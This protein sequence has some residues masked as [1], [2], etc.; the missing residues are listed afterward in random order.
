MLKNLFILFWTLAS[1]AV[2]GLLGYFYLNKYEIEQRFRYLWG[3]YEYEFATSP[4]IVL[5]IPRHVAACSEVSELRRL[6]SLE[7]LTVDGACNINIAPSG[8]PWGVKCPSWVPDDK[9]QCVKL[10]TFTDNIA[11]YHSR[12]LKAHDEV[13]AYLSE[14]GEWSPWIAA[15]KKFTSL[16]EDLRSV[17]DRTHLDSVVATSNVKHNKNANHLNISLVYSYDGVRDWRISKMNS[18]FGDKPFEGT[19]ILE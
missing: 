18:T 12:S 7:L 14:S 10:K 9:M 5:K 11:K 13:S 6:V 8:Q 4:F 16:F 15:D 19:F 2:F 3:P 1:L 17:A